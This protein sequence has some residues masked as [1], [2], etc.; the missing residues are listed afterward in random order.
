MS[1]HVARDEA[2]RRG[3]DEMLLAAAEALEVVADA[4]ANAPADM[5]TKYLWKLAVQ[6][7]TLRWVLCSMQSAQRKV[8][9]K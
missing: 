3:Q 5:P 8:W 2:R 4:I 9:S 6:Q 1:F 7:D